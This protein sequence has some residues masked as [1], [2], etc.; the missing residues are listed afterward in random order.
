MNMC[1]C[2]LVTEWASDPIWA[3]TQAKVT[4]DLT[5]IPWNTANL[6]CWQPHSPTSKPKSLLQWLRVHLVFMFVPVHPLYRHKPVIIS[7]SFGIIHSCHTAGFILLR[8]LF[9]SLPS[10]SKKC[11]L[12]F[13][14]S[15][16][17]YSHLQLAYQPPHPKTLIL[18]VPCL[19]LK[20]TNDRG[21]QKR[22]EAKETDEEPFWYTAAGKGRENWLNL[23]ENYI[24]GS[25]HL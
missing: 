4:S 16:S 8:L 10:W 15:A 19:N 7:K 5:F 23:D 11:T 18:E 17:V 21:L 2:M 20:S 13:H 24:K 6:S 9:P 25:I 22:I 1:V 12:H 3:I 14:L